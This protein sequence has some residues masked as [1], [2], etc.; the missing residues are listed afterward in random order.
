MSAIVSLGF[1]KGFWLRRMKILL[2]K[3]VL[4]TRLTTLAL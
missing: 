4:L 2:A 3:F 1:E